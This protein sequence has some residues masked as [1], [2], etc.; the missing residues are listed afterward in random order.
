MPATYPYQQVVVASSPLPVLLSVQTHCASRP[1]HFRVVILQATALSRGQPNGPLPLLL[2]SLSLARSCVLHSRLILQYFTFIGLYASPFAARWPS[3][4]LL[5]TPFLKP[6]T[7]LPR[8]ETHR[9]PP[10]SSSSKAHGPP[11]WPPPTAS[12]PPSDPSRPRRIS[13]RRPPWAPVASFHA[14]SR[15]HPPCPTRQTAPRRTRPSPVVACPACPPARV[16]PDGRTHP[17]PRDTRSTATM[18]GRGGGATCG[19]RPPISPPARS[20]A[21]A[22]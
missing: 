17:L 9:L 18:R 4:L 20:P 21:R 7:A 19:P 6:S 14:V 5:R 16:R 12:I 8:R 10:D 13:R 2:Y 15:R 3:I 11:R 1:P 22:S